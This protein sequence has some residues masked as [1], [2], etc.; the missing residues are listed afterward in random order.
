MV[1]AIGIALVHEICCH[2][3][4]EANSSLEIHITSI[5]G[6]VLPLVAAFLLK[7]YLIIILRLFCN[8]N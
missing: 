7:L 4:K 2:V 8:E 5:A 3:I 6:M 1:I